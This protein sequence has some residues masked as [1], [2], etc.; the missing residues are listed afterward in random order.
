VPPSVVAAPLLLGLAPQVR[1]PAVVLAVLLFP[2]LAIA[3]LRGAPRAI[4]AA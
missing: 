4:M 1:L 2:L 3:A